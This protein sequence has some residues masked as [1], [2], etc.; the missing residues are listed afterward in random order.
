MFI[1]RNNIL[2]KQTALTLVEVLLV[3][4]MIGVVSLALYQAL[5]NGLRIWERSRVSC[6]EEDAMFFL[7]KLTMDLRNAF[8]FSLFEFEG[9]QDRIVFSTI[10]AVPMAASGSDEAVVYIDQIGRVEYGFDAERKAV[11]RRQ[12]NYGQAVKNEFGPRQVLANPVISVS[13][14]YF[15]RG[16][17]GLS[18]RQL[19]Q[20]G[21][22][23]AV[24]VLLQY[25]DIHGQT[26]EMRR[27]INLPLFFNGESKP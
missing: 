12:A 10:V 9:E 15:M 13:F 18:E 24:E 7:D 27:M 25:T 5:S 16:E 22:P 21:L 17:L 26:Q 6:V 1:F 14:K 19:D 4:A 20:E 11:F 3:S 23:E 8:T 2:K